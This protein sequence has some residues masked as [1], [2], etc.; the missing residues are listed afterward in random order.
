MNIVISS[1]G[2]KCTIEHARSVQGNAVL[3]ASLFEEYHYNS[4]E[5]KEEFAIP[6]ARTPL[7]HFFAF[8]S[9]LIISAFLV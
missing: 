5:E 2:L 1:K 8:F 4:N 6:L 7:L 9:S 3:D